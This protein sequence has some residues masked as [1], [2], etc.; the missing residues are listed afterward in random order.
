M[1]LVYQP[2]NHKINYYLF[3]LLLVTEILILMSWRT[4]GI[5]EISEESSRCFIINLIF[6][7]LSHKNELKE[8]ST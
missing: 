5:Y 2:R 8:R 1:S 6:S 7:E 3:C 4:R